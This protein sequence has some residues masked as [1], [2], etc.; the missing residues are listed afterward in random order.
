MITDSGNIKSLQLFFKNFKHLRLTEQATLANVSISTIKKWRSKCGIRSDKKSPFSKTIAKHYDIVPFDIWHNPEW[1]RQK[2]EVEGFGRYV[3]SKMIDRNIKTVYSYLK[4]YNIKTR[5]VKIN[6][7]CTKEW[8]TEN[9]EILGY[10]IRKCAELANVS[11]YTIYA[12]LVK[13]R[14]HIRDR[15]EAFS[16]ERNPNYGIKRDRKHISKTQNKDDM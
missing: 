4:R 14:I 3:I 12:W 15:Y 16:G 10:G 9:Y 11:A 2:Y 1:F 6:P 8:L 7:L 5:P 13:H